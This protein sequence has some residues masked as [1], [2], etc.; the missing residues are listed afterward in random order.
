MF[1]HC[2]I[3]TPVSDFGPSWP[4]CYKTILKWRKSFG[5]TKFY[6]MAK[7][8]TNLNKVNQ[9]ILHINSLNV[10]R[11]QKLIIRTLWSVQMDSESP[12]TFRAAFI[13]FLYTDH[14]LRKKKHTTTGPTG[15]TD[16][17]ITTVPFLQF[18][19]FTFSNSRGFP[20]IPWYLNLY[21]SQNIVGLPLFFPG[22]CRKGLR[23][24]SCIR[25]YRSYT[26]EYFYFNWGRI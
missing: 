16:L 4:S 13:P 9:T 15:F 23:A 19:V 26:S 17:K 1:C 7:I 12:A 2:Y 21:R 10:K 6:S 24:N 22:Y 11:A 20:A 8:W 5:G 25:H 18:P 3:S 14:F